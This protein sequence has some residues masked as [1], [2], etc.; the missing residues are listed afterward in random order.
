MR[1]LTGDPRQQ[2]FRV[3]N[4]AGG[5]WVTFP[6]VGT[7]EQPITVTVEAQE[8]NPLP[9]LS[10]LTFDLSGN[11]TEVVDAR[12]VK[13]ELFY[14]LANRLYRV[15]DALGNETLIAYTA[16]GQ[17]ATVIDP[18]KNVTEVVYDDAG[19]VARVV[20]PDGHEIR[21]LWMPST[22]WLRSRPPTETWRTRSPSISAVPATD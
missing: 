9:V 15:L 19:R 18:R 5:V 10:A 8:N 12:G 2:T 11:I 17:L 13:T 20:Q 6:V 4:N 16:A 1:H 3:P 22:A 7:T 21:T 14:T